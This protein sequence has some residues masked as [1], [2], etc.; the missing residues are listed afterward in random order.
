MASLV[1][2]GN[3]WAINTN[4]IATNIFYF[5]IS[6]SGAYTLQDN[7]TIDGQ[8]ITAGELVVKS[9]YLCSMKVY[10]NWYWGQHPQ[11]HVIRVP[12]HTIIHPQLEFNA[13]TDFHAITTSVC[14]RTQ[15]KKAI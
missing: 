13:V 14:T 6:A 15:E 12:T 7:T 11:Q 8:M 4:D 5:I 10:T 1:E 9:Q 3:Y 2:S